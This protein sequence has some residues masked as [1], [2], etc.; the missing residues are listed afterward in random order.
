MQNQKTFSNTWTQVP[1]QEVNTQLLKTSTHRMDESHRYNP[2]M[3]G[4]DTEEYTVYKAIYIRFSHRTLVSTGEE[5]LLVL[6]R[7]G[8]EELKMMFCFLTSWWL[9]EHSGHKHVTCVSFYISHFNRSLFNTLFIPLH[10][11]KR[12]RN[13]NLKSDMKDS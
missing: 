3:N 7:M 2:H 1:L 4:A 10:Q 6:T 9:H 12:K 11:G 5:R 13:N 8:L